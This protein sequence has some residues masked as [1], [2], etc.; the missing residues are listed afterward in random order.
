MTDSVQFF[1]RPCCG[2]SAAS[3]LAD[4]LRERVGDAAEVEYHNLNAT[5]SEPVSVPTAVI[6]HLSTQGALPVMTVNGRIVAAGDLPNLMDALD[7]ATGR[8][9]APTATITLAQGKSGCC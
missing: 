8:A 2:P 9:T 5:G 6:S 7:L 1:D 4:F 3:N